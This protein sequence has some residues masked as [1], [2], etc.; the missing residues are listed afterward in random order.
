MSDGKVEIDIEEG[1]MARLMGERVQQTEKEN[2]QL[3]ERVH[4]F[5]REK[6]QRDARVHQL[7]RKRATRRT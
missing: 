5:G 7:E 3:A 6:E 1:E 4:Q 2:E